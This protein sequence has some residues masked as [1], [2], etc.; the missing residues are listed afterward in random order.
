M[1]QLNEQAKQQGTELATLLSA[2]SGLD[3][4]P[5]GTIHC[6]TT[7]D[8]VIH[9]NKE[10]QKLAMDAEL[11]APLQQKVP[12]HPVKGLFEINKHNKQ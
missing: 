3:G 4:L 10:S 7:G 6:N 12:A 11:P 9:L 2:S 1:Q 5:K 8:S